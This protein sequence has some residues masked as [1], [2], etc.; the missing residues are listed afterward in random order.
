MLSISKNKSKMTTATV[1]FTK[2]LPKTR[3]SPP[4]VI[5]QTAVPRIISQVQPLP[6]IQKQ[7]TENTFRQYL[8]KFEQINPSDL[9]FTLGKKLRYAIDTIHKQQVVKT[10]Y[11]LGGI[12][13][14][15]S[16]SNVV[17][18]NPYAKKTWS[19]KIQQP[20]KRLRFYYKK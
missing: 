18:S 1:K 7:L 20:G 15:V 8:V 19:V 6:G 9:N 5:Q 17:L 16:N 13:I 12:V 14:S 3:V 2:T 4:L 11:R 10:D